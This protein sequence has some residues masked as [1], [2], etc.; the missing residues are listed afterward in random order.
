MQVTLKHREETLQLSVFTDAS[1]VVWSGLLTQIPC[2]DLKLDVDEKWNLPLSSLS[3]KFD[4][5]HA[6]WYIL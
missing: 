2:A 4:E 1:Y 3:G 5:T 6:C